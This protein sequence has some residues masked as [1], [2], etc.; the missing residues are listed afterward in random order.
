MSV[1]AP[2][3]M[4]HRQWDVT[5][6]MEVR[7]VHRRLHPG[8]G[9]QGQGAKGHGDLSYNTPTHSQCRQTGEI[10]PKNTK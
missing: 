4:R 1:R 9:C 7:M 3:E 5:D 10:V 6:E 2:K 8:L